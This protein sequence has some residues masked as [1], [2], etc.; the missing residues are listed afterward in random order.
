MN[1]SEYR[2]GKRKKN[3]SAFTIVMACCLVALGA[4][5]WLT[6]RSIRAGE[7]ARNES[8]M[9]SPS[10][11][12]PAEDSSLTPSS[13]QSENVAKPVKDEPYSEPESQPQEPPAESKQETAVFVM[14]VQ[15][16]ILKSYNDRELQYSATYGD[17]RLHT[18]VDISC[19]EGTAVS[20]AAN[21]T[22]T[23]VEDSAELGT[24]ITVDHGN[25]VLSRYASIKEAKVKPGDQV[26]AGDVIG[27]V[28]SIPGECADQS[29]LHFEMV[30]G[31]YYA[32]P[33]SLIKN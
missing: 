5:L 7:R 25:S 30:K 31:G 12:S 18:A 32:D 8:S 16:E 24:V 11:V 29:H 1:Y 14:P 9:P 17:M 33:F 20:A 4:A 2:A 22:V 10:L 3:F 19:E 15:G 6:G 13:E 28:G 27:T 23:A 26:A 21:G